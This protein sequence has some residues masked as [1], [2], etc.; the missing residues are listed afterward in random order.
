MFKNFQEAV[1]AAYLDQ[2]NKGQLPFEKAQPS[3]GELQAWCLQRS[4]QKLSVEDV[5]VLTKF[6]ASRQSEKD[7]SVLI[8]N[9]DLDKLRPLRN[10]ITGYT[11]TP[12]EIIVK[13][14][15]VLI[16]FQP[17]PYKAINWGEQVHVELA[18][19]QLNSKGDYIQ[20]SHIELLGRKE[21]N[22]WKRYI[23]PGLIA[24]F[25]LLGF[26]YYTQH[27]TECMCWNGMRYVEVDCQD[28]EQPYQVI[29]LD[30]DKLLHFQKIM[31]PDTLNDTHIGRVWYSKIDNKVEFFTAPGHHPVSYN[32]SLKAATKHIID[33][34]AHKTTP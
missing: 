1:K 18:E 34:Y 4:L 22:N 23:A 25:L 19:K 17:R 6:F 24:L 13:L 3:T 2:K 28:M 31:H 11:K 30:K 14:L 21:K 10:F 5:E 26:V 7:L 12:S 16:D 33:K 20:A 29:G 32:K 9:S 15:A 8:E 27:A